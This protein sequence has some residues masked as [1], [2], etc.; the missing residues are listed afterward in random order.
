MILSHFEGHYLDVV[1]KFQPPVVTKSSN[2]S[3]EAESSALHQGQN[4][5]FHRQKR[6][7]FFYKKALSD[8][9]TQ[10]LYNSFL[11]KVLCN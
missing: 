1:L 3:S 7:V 11:I 8:E 5:S 10:K 6:G 2:F 9:I 4:R